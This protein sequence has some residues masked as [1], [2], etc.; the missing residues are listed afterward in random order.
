MVVGAEAEDVVLAA[1]TVV[2]RARGAAAGTIGV[3]TFPADPSRLV[4]VDGVESGCV[5]DASGDDPELVSDETT[6]HSTPTETPLLD[7]EPVPGAP[8]LAPRTTE[9]IHSPTTPVRSL[10][11]L[12]AANVAMLPEGL[13]YV[14]RGRRVLGASRA[15]RGKDVVVIPAG[16]SS[17]ACPISTRENW[18][19]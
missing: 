10:G 17:R 3:C 16:R 18:S 2:R 7:H 12:S 13:D 14:V 5:G 8:E 4:R 6:S 15:G 9:E 19:G 11:P 1:G